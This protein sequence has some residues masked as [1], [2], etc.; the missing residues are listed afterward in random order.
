MNL[1]LKGGS[2]F[3]GLPVS[4]TISA[5]LLMD[6]CKSPAWLYGVVFTFLGLVWISTIILWFTEK[7]ISLE[8]IV[9]KK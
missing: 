7:Y 4:L 9:N 1:R 6:K 8:D 5:Y 3:S 2:V